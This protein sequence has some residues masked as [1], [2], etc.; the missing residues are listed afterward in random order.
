MVCV[1][2]SNI[3]IRGSTISASLICNLRAGTIESTRPDLIAIQIFLSS[4]IC[5]FPYLP[6]RCCLLLEFPKR[7]RP[8]GEDRNFQPCKRTNVEETILGRQSL[9]L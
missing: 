7:C 9:A 2:V 5:S 6:V 4:L 3:H 1:P 8:A